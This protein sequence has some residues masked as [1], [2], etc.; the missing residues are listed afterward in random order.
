M[1]ISIEKLKLKRR[2]TR[3]DIEII[4]TYLNNLSTK[5]DYVLNHLDQDNFVE[6]LATAKYVKGQINTIKEQLA[7]KGE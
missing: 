3:E 6:E 4:E 7:Q 5:L 2:S 1:Q